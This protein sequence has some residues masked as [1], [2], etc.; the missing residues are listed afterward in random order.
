MTAQIQSRYIFGATCSEDTAKALRKNKQARNA[1][2]LQFMV[3][4]T[5]VGHKTHYVCMSGGRIKD[6][7][8]ELTLV[9]QGALEALTALPFKGSV[10]I[11]AECKLGPTPLQDK[12][13]Q[14]ILDAPANALICFV[15][16]L[17]KELDGHMTP[18]FNMTGEPIFLPGY[19]HLKNE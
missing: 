9:G 16:D 5:S 13:K 7:K 3:M 11:F 8:P 18:A 19:E 15:G 14:V 10:L 12:I 2:I 17:A 6:G 4:Q 1:D